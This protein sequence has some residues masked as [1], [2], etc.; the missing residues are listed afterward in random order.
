[1]KKSVYLYILISAFCFGTM[2][3][4]LKLA[5]ASLDPFQITFL[6]FLIGGIVLIIPSVLERRGQPKIAMKDIIYVAMLGIL[7]VDICMLFFQ[8]GIMH[9][10]AA[11]AAVIFS[12]NPI[13]TILLSHFLM[14]D[15]KLNTKKV[16]AIC[17]GALGTIFMIRP[18]N[19]Q[20]G[21][22]V[23]GA[24]LMVIA[25][26]LFGLYGIL[27][28]KTVSRVG[29]FTQT[30]LSFLIGSAV[31]LVYMLIVGRPIVLGISDNIS[32][33]LYVS[34]IVTGCGYLTYFLAIKHASPSTASLVFFL[35]P[36]IAP[37]AAFIVLR[38]VITYNM[39]IGIAL[40]LV[41]SG[42]ILLH[43]RS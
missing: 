40:I 15:D 28:K 18:W 22:T 27:G 11:T 1:M 6:R 23:L 21:N 24:V 25:A 33:L 16:C 42:M 26:F 39:Y 32:V 9:A 14:K 37:V 10:N 13:F 41:G 4:A 31:M 12:C 34:V 38:E 7:N 29:T 19:I 20:P 36:V 8:F 30:C 43:T 3:V 2:E 17:F 5:D 35:K